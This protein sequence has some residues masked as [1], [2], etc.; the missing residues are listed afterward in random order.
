M[1]DLGSA[2]EQAGGKAQNREGIT[3]KTFVASLATALILF[4][5]E[6]LLFLILKSKL[7]RI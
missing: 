4:A 5:V 1:T 3:V 6:F 7:V 2:L